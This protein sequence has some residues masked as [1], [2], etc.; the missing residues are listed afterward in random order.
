MPSSEGIIL[1]TRDRW[2]VRS[3]ADSRRRELSS[4]RSL[5]LRYLLWNT[6]SAGGS[7]TQQSILHDQ[8]RDTP[9]RTILR[10]DGLLAFFPSWRNPAQPMA[11]S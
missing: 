7:I 3:I 9:N 10:M 8:R 4:Q 11:R 1:D 6:I 5:C 2:K